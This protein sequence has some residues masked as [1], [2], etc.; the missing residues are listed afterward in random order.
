M[1]HPRAGRSRNQLAA[2]PEGP[3]RPEPADMSRPYGAVSAVFAVPDGCSDQSIMHRPVE[4]GN[5][6]RRIDLRCQLQID[7]DRLDDSA[8]FPVAYRPGRRTLH[9]RSRRVGYPQ[10]GSILNFFGYVADTPAPYTT[11]MDA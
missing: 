10:T 5:A 4:R 7:E 8:S 3:S 2:V 9:G 11:R 1:P 6:E